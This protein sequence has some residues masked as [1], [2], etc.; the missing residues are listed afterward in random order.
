M[1]Y[2][3]DCTIVGDSM[4][5]IEALITSLHD[6]MENFI[7]Q[8]EG[9]INKC[10]GVRITQ[11]DDLSFIIQIVLY[12]FVT[13]LIQICYIQICYIQFC[14]KLDTKWA[15]GVLVITIFL[16]RRPA[17]CCSGQIWHSDVKQENTYSYV[18]STGTRKLKMTT[19]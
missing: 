6:G 12:Q 3:D 10:L 9:S 17:E 4:D 19:L 11:L 8:D 5:C 1:T 15:Q 13:K 2:V 16:N 18:I 7:V 14:I